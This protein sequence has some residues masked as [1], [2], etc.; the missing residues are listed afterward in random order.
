[1][2]D[3]QLGKTRLFVDHADHGRFL[4]P[5]DLAF[6]HC[7]N[8]GYASRLSGQA[9]LTEEIAGS[10]HCDDGFFPLLGNN[11]NLHIA[12]LD[13]ENSIGRVP[14]NKDRLLFGKR[15][16]LPTAVD[17]RKECFGIELAASLAR[18]HG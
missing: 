12:L 14:L 15:C 4:Q 1:M 17:G 3:E 11:G 5:H 13:I 10:Q 7:G 18:D 8:R 16:N 2:R 6:G 9:P